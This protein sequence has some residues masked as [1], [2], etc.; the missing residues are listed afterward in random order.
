MCAA[1]DVPP[2]DVRTAG[3]CDRQTNVHRRMCAAGDAAPQDVPPQGCA[4][5]DVARRRMCAAGRWMPAGCAT[6]R[7][8]EQSGDV[9]FTD[10]VQPQD[11]RRSDVPAGCVHNLLHGMLATQELIGRRRIVRSRRCATQDGCTAKDV[12]RQDV[13]HI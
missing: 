8:C 7:M 1:G 5:Q 11:V 3:D 2:Q 6:R 10:D 4:P 13:W 12:R 9:H